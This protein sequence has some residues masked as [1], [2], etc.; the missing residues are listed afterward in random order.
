[1]DAPRSRSNIS[2]SPSTAFAVNFAGGRIWNL[3]VPRSR[4]AKTDRSNPA[5]VPAKPAL[6]DRS[7]GG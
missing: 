7:V 2:T 4:V 6:H 1:M 3:K 5:T